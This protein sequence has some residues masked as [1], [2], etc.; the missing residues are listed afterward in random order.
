MDDGVVGSQVD[1]L[2]DVLL[3]SLVL[4]VVIIP[5]DCNNDE[6]DFDKSMSYLTIAIMMS[7]GLI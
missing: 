1:A 2:Q 5:D 7:M 3:C 4:H 6:Y